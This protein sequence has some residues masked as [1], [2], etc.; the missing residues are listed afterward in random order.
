MPQSATA[1]PRAQLAL[2]WQWA[3]L[4]ELTA[5]D[6]YAVLAARQEVFAVEQ[7]C[8]FQDAD[9]LDF[10]AWHLL[11]WDHAGGRRTLACYL[12]LI[13]PGRKFAEPSIG[14]V[15]TTSAYRGVGLGR[16]LML[17]GMARAARAFPGVPIRI[18]AQ[19]RLEAFYASLGYVTVGAPFLEDNIPHVEMLYSAG[20][21]EPAQ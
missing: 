21:A 17:E 2:D 6:V 7:S 19:Q 12:R 1:H 5:A 4:S 15:L 14:R 11:G 13:D 10:H 8:A 16:T 18:A 20:R 3:R 9:G